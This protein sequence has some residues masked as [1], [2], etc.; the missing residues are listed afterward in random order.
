MELITT[1]ATGSGVV[2]PANQ[3]RCS[4][5]LVAISAK[6]ELLRKPLSRVWRLSIVAGRGGHVGD[7]GIS[8]LSPNPTNLAL[9]TQMYGPAVRSKKISTSWR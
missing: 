4:R 6:A 7:W 3:P 1:G 9:M 2:C 8:G 5:H